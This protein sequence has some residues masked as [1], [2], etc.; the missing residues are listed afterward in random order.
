MRY[1]PDQ[2]EESK[3]SKESERMGEMKKIV[4]KVLQDELPDCTTNE[5]FMGSPNFANMVDK[6]ME[7]YWNEV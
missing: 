6:I 2:P 7:R 5:W 4:E 1:Y 3:E